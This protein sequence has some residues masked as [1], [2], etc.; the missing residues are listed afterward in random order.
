MQINKVCSPS[1][2]G[3]YIHKPEMTQAQINYSNDI[4]D[5]FYYSDAYQDSKY[6]VDVCFLPAASDGVKISFIDKTNDSY[7]KKGI[8]SSLIVKTFRKPKNGKFTP[9]DWVVDI[10]KRFMNGEI[11]RQEPS[12][13]RIVNKETDAAKLRPEMYEEVDELMQDAVNILGYKEDSKEAKEYVADAFLRFHPIASGDFD[14]GLGYEFA[15][16]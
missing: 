15:G 3:I 7:L 8:N 10:L 1:F 13:K 2:K 11:K 9:S 5:A 14:R 6:D 12:V 16:E 4:A